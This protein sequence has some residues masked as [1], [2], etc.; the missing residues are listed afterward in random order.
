MQSLNQSISPSMNHSMNLDNVNV[1]NNHTSM[2][3][4]KI[5]KDIFVSRIHVG[6]YFA[7]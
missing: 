3:A 5:L 2:H 6:T 4:I 1:S 7:K